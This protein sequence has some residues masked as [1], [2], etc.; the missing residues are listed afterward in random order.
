M[1]VTNIKSQSNNT[2]TSKTKK[3]ANSLTPKQLHFVRCIAQGMTQADSYREA[4]NSKNMSNQNIYEE[5][6]R[7]MANPKISTRVATLIASKEA[8][9]TRSTVGLRKKVLDK[10][11]DFM[12]SAD[13]E[14]GNK[15]RAAELLGK[16]IG[17]FKEVIEDNRDKQRTPEELTAI[18]EAK[19][20][21]LQD[22]TKH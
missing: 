9:I 5:A 20:L 19:L 4:Y 7:L 16:S 22:T 2:V 10:L 15:I 12:D 18:L 8:A 1:S 14:D 13:K 17:L 21:K 3:K 6:S 11:E